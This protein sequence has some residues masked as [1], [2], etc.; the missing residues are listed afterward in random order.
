M[1]MGWLWKSRRK[2]SAAG[3]VALRAGRL[4]VMRSPSFIARLPAATRGSRLAGNAPAASRKARPFQGCRRARPRRVCTSRSNKQPARSQVAPR[5]WHFARQIEQ[6]FGEGG[7][8]RYLQRQGE[9]QKAHA[10][11]GEGGGTNFIEKTGHGTVSQTANTASVS[12]PIINPLPA[13]STLEF[14]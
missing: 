11:Q 12:V 2:E 14:T 8:K 6:N 7:I 5:G 9:I 1:G 10:F 3:G 4:D 13:I